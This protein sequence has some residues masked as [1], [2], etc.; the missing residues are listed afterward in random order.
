MDNRHRARGAASGPLLAKF[1]DHRPR[2]PPTLHN[3]H[4][5][6]AAIGMEHHDDRWRALANINDGRDTYQLDL[7]IAD[8]HGR[9]IVTNVSSPG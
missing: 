4:P 2:V 7:T 3:L 1:K 9:W 6:V 8:H 5:Q